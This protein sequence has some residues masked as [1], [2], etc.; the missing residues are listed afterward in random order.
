MLGKH[1][2]PGCPTNLDSTREGPI[3]V[4][5]ETAGVCFYIC[6]LVYLFSFLLPLWKTAR[7]RLKF[8][9]KGTLNRK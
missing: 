5:V 8:C 4:A 7:Y 1:S 2:V 9:L 6:S 3:A